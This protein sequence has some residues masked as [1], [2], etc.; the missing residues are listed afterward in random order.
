MREVEGNKINL[1]QYKQLPEF[2]QIEYERICSF[3]TNNIFNY[4]EIEFLSNVE[5]EVLFETQEILDKKS[6]FKEWRHSKKTIYNSFKIILESTQNEECVICS[7]H[8][9]LRNI[10]YFHLSSKQSQYIQY[11]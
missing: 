7:N 9:H 10:S 6:F 5:Y 11:S 1:Y 8:L 4:K 2:V 3:P